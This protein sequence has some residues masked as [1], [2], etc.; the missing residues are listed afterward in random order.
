MNTL[1]TSA[2][3]RS[4]EFDRQAVAVVRLMKEAS[5]PSLLLKGAAVARWLYPP[6][7]TRPAGDVDLLI[8]TSCWDTAADLLRSRGMH[9]TSG[10]PDHATMWEPPVPGELSVDLHRSFHFVTVSPEL[11]WSSL[12]K[13]AETIVLAGEPVAVPSR[14]ALAV[15]LG[16]HA[17]ADGHR[18]RALAELALAIERE[19]L[20]LW[21]AAANLAAELGA[22]DAFAAALR[23]APGGGVIAAQLALP[24]ASRLEVELALEAT[25]SSY[26]LAR[27][28]EAASRGG[29]LSAALRELLPPPEQMRGR[30][31]PFASRGRTGLALSYALRPSVVVRRLPKALGAWR[32]A[33]IRSGLADAATSRSSFWW[34]ARVTL[35]VMAAYARLYRQPERAGISSAI[36]LAR[37]GAP[38]TVE[39]R[40]AVADARRLGTAVRRV[41]ALLPG[42]TSCLIES[43]VL[44]R[45]LSRRGITA[46]VVLA[47][48]RGA[49]TQAHAWVEV[50]QQ[51]VLP[52]AGAEFARLTEL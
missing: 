18:S 35:E 32:R 7:T 40:C 22:L 4:L 43:L 28:S 6:G 16:L 19:Q 3:L 13:R 15:L 36:G 5:V 52:P 12:V 21:E 39:D 8:P 9:A 33:R 1:L 34:R 10:S 41:C 24:S 50:A 14:P 45:L 51:P 42:R 30:H 25:P 47:V 20:G 48:A 49:E 46:R 26:G 31:F 23:A 27:L 29:L 37:R 17:A 11:C 44:L 38:L 2:A